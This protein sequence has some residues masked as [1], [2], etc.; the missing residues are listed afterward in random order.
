SL[1]AAFQACGSRS[2]HPRSMKYSRARLHSDCSLNSFSGHSCG[3]LLHLK[4]Q[5]CRE[6]FSQ[7]KCL[8]PDDNYA[9]FARETLSELP[10]TILLASF[11]QRSQ[12]FLAG[13]GVALKES[14]KSTAH[15]ERRTKCSDG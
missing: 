10:G 6:P 15:R 3:S 9:I 5:S 8:I 11:P 1:K 14:N 4:S 13:I 12:S 7:A 2:T